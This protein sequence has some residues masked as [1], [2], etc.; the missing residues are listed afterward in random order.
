MGGPEDAINAHKAVGGGLG[1]KCV[2]KCGRSSVHLA[3]LAPSRKRKDEQRTLTHF[4]ET[5]WRQVQGRGRMEE[6]EKVNEEE[7]QKRKRGNT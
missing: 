4:R 5:W 6:E 3:I 7:L 2:T 1:T